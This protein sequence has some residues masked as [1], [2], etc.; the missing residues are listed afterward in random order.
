MEMEIVNAAGLAD[1]AAL[2]ALADPTRRRLYGLV[3]EAGRPLGRDEAVAA[4]GISRSLAAYHLDKLAEQG[5]LEVEYAR[6]PGRAGPGAGRPAKL[7]R[8]AAREFVLRAPPRDYQLLAELLVRTA[9]DDEQGVIHGA[10]ER[11]AAELGEQLGAAAQSLEQILRERGYEA[12]E[13]EPGHLRL[14]NCPFAAVAAQ[15]PAF[16]CRL[17]L[18]LI[19]GILVGLGADPELA[20]LVPRK[21]E[22][23]VALRLT[24]A[25]ARA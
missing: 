24:G 4:V 25:A 15:C 16:V 22:C 14:R 20:S 3:V 9:A 13:A 7:Y 23:C 8:R 5:L 6:P 11:A 18:A 21:G 1:L 2:S 17:N 10:I 19:R 12:V